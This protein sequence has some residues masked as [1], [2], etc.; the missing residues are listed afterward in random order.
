MAP[1]REEKKRMGKKHRQASTRPKLGKGP[2]KG[3]RKGAAVTGA[4]SPRQR[5][6]IAARKA[7][8]DRAN[9]IPKRSPEHEHRIVVGDQD[10]VPVRSKRANARAQSAPV[11]TSIANDR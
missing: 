5:K 6:V 1:R 8:T 4:V 3:A 11:S 2:A 9:L 7:A 10:D